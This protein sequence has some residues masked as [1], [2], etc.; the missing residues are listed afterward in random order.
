MIS[1][2]FDAI[3]PMLC[4]T[5]AGLVVLLAEAFRGRNERM[6]IGGLAIIGLVG[7]GAATILLWASTGED[8]S[9]PVSFGVVAADRFGLFINM[10]LVVVGLLTVM[11]SSQTIERDKLPAGE[12]YAMM[13]FAIVGMMLMAQATDLLV[14]FLALETMSIAVYVLTGMRRDQQQST[15]AAFK[16]FLLGAFASAFFLY[17]IAFLFGATGTTNID[18]MSTTIAAQSMSDNPMILIG[19]GLLIVGFAFKIA[20]VPFHMWSP[21]AYE[22]APTVVT[23]FMSTAVKAAAIAAFVRVFLKGLDPLLLQWAPVLWWIAAA[24]MIVGT[25]VGV[26]QTSVKRMLAYSSIAHG[27]FILAGLIAGNDEGKAA[28]LFYLAAYGLTNMGAFGVIAMLGTRE[29]ANDDLRDYAG[30]FHSHPG[31]AILMTFFLLSLGGFPPTAGFIAKW[32]VFSAVIGAT[33]QGSLQTA[34]VT[35]GYTLAIIGLLSSVVS[36]FFY[37]RVVVMM[38]MTDRDARPVPAP[39][40]AVAMAGLIISLIGVLYLG[41]LPSRVIDIAQASIGTIF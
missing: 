12:Y 19:M 35:G 30:L 33:E 39:V 4:V 27:G 22:G 18:A 32:Y 10:V 29:R 3:I 1:G 40:P 5:L 11:F 17:G 26:A 14:I 36:V 37:L 7:A 28:I 38:Y 2:Q 25:V 9:G 23:G 6:P 8:G 15:E 24:T 13:L 31:L 41:V 16:Y 21:D 34:A 20:A